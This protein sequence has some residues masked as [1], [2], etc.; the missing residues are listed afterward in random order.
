[1][2]R[3]QALSR[4]A[5]LLGGAVIGAESFLRGSPPS[6]KQPGP[7]FSGEELALMDE[8][9][10]TIIPTTDTPGA[11]AAAIGAFMGMMVTDCYDDRHEAVFRAGLR[12]LD[13]ACRKRHGKSFVEC[14][15]DQRSELLTELD[16]ERTGNGGQMAKDDAPHY[17]KMLKELTLL[18][19]FTSEI[20]CT[21]ALRYVETP[22]GFQGNVPYKKGDRAW[23]VPPGHSLADSNSL[24]SP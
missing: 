1:M 9:G 22:G 14:A 2:N 10:E 13:E 8:I 7:A 4:L 17:L 24:K 23:F 16:R 3:R 19:Y 15:P 21:Q 6:G 18:G 11:K 5:L 12:D 20:G